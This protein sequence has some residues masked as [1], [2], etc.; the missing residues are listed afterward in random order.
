LYISITTA[1]KDGSSIYIGKS[2]LSLHNVLSAMW[3]AEW[4]SQHLLKSVVFYI[5]RVHWQGNLRCHQSH[6]E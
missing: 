3:L 6:A 2:W 1:G 5:S 4:Y